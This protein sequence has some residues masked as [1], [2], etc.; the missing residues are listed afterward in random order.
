MDYTIIENQV[1]EKIKLLFS[2]LNSQFTSS[3]ITYEILLKRDV[4]NTTKNYNSEIEIIFNKGGVFFDIIE[5]F[6]F[7]NGELYIKEDNL[8]S[9]LYSDIEG[10]LSTV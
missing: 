10:I 8:L 9:E 2:S 4:E 3:D 7:R 1:D 6:V 5:F